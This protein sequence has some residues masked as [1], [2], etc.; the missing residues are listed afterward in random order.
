MLYQNKNFYSKSNQEK[1]NTMLVEKKM[2]NLKSIR[3]T[4]S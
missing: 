2:L 3:G 1:D 4:E